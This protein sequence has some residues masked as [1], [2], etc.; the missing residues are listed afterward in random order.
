LLLSGTNRKGKTFKKKEVVYQEDTLPAG[1]FY[2]V[3]GK[4]KICRNNPEGKELITT[5]LANGD[6][7]GYTTLLEE[8]PY[9]DSAI[10]LED[11]EVI[12]IPKTD[13]FSL[14]Y[15]NRDVAHTFI[16]LL[17]NNVKEKEERL[18]KIAY[19]SVRKR[20]AEA[21]IMLR[22]RYA[23]ANTNPFS[24]AISRDDLANLAGTASET[25]IRTLSDF[26][27]EKIIAIKGSTVTI[28]EEEKLRRM[29]N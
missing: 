17:S 23:Q 16:R 7:F 20:V 28:L 22:E 9:S 18:L 26:R 10:A 8:T 25:V 3:K 2:L 13:F 27:D 6:F 11:S 1:V 5:L 12:I 21:L 4:I 24:M 15:K 14:I 19:N 29:K